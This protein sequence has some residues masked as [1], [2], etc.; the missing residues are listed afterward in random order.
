MDPAPDGGV[1]MVVAV[2][3]DGVAAWAASV[4]IALVL[5]LIFVISSLLNT[6]FLVI[7]FRRPALRS[8]SNRKEETSTY[9]K[10]GRGAY[11]TLH[12]TPRPPHIPLLPGT[13]LHPPPPDTLFTPSRPYR[14]PITM[15]SSV[16]NVLEPHRG[17]T[18]HHPPHHHH[19]H[20]LASRAT[21]PRLYLRVTRA[22]GGR[23]A[24]RG[25]RDTPARAPTPRGMAG[26]VPL[27]PTLGH[28]LQPL[29][30]TLGNP[31]HPVCHYCLPNTSAPLNATQQIPGFF[32]LPSAPRPFP[33]AQRGGV[34]ERQV[35][36]RSH[37]NTAD[38]R[39][40]A[41]GDLQYRIGCQGGADGEGG[42][43]WGPFK[44]AARPP[45]SCDHTDRKHCPGLIA[46]MGHVGC[47]GRAFCLAPLCTCTMGPA[48]IA[49]RG[50][51]GAALQAL[52]TRRGHAARHMHRGKKGP[53]LPT[54]HSSVGCPLA[55][56]ASHPVS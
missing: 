24:G 47:V 41:V 32:C 33:L 35:E 37:H 28:P 27:N 30:P 8:V 26:V 22:G 38:C 49:G 2:D 20:V 43:W 16:P 12:P 48:G 53:R 29:T 18:L 5:G 9:V 40:T 54:G 14:T 15:M 7:F 21:D 3:A 46:L 34:G 23:L 11:V 56:H 44:G 31:P 52:C 4:T 17:R 50:P 19:R 10:R 45:R 39:A 6:V 55:A 42:G 36:I 51:G 1:V 13:L 25:R